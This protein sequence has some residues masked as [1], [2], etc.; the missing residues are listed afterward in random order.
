MY[1]IRDLSESR[2][3]RGRIGYDMMPEVNCFYPAIC[4]Q[5]DSARG[6][7]VIGLGEINGG[8]ELCLLVVLFVCHK[9]HVLFLHWDPA[10]CIVPYLV[11]KVSSWSTKSWLEASFFPHLF[12]FRPCLVGNLELTRLWDMRKTSSI[13]QPHFFPCFA[14][15]C[16][17]LYA[18]QTFN[19]NVNEITQESIFNDY[20]S[21]MLLPPKLK[22]KIKTNFLT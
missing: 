7:R 10:S 21:H 8:N 6:T 12:L 5:T 9:R 13:M 11:F 16:C 20:K 2:A 3:E 14:W 22:I 17:L 18:M 15:L 4:F 19:G 1:S